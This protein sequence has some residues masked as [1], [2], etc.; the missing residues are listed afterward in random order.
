MNITLSHC[1]SKS[2]YV[3]MNKQLFGHIVAI[4]RQVAFS[5]SN[6]TIQLLGSPFPPLNVIARFDPL[7]PKSPGCTFYFGYVYN[8][9][10]SK[11]TDILE[12]GLKSSALETYSVMYSKTLSGM[13][14]LFFSTF[15]YKFSYF[16]SFSVLSDFLPL[17]SYSQTLESVV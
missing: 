8:L 10:I 11:N 2:K 5:F 16:L 6:S 3:L 9:T 14:L 15:I 17:I 12:A 7:L 13:L 1:A 4:S